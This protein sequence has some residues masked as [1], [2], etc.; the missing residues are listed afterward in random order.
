MIALI[1]LLI[2]VWSSTISSAIALVLLLVLVIHVHKSA[3]ESVDMLYKETS[4]F[5]RK[6]KKTC[7][8]F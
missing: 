1:L 5:N 2:L 6:K 3:R 8:D 7:K 4:D